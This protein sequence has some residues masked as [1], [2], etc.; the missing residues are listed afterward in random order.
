MVTVGTD[1]E[2]KMDW[3]SRGGANAA[4]VGVLARGTSAVRCVPEAGVGVM[5]P[6][7]VRS[8]VGFD[9]TGS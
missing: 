7:F 2:I 3:G 8:A 6:V 9:I 4:E 5:P 1:F